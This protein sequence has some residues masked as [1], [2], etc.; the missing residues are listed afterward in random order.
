MKR[1]TCLVKVSDHLQHPQRSP[2]LSCQSL[3][4]SQTT[5]SQKEPIHFTSFRMC[6]IPSNASGSLR[7]ETSMPSCLLL[8]SHLKRC[9][10]FTSSRIPP[11]A[12]IFNDVT[13]ST[14][15]SNPLFPLHG[16]SAISPMHIYDFG[17]RQSQSCGCDSNGEVM[18]R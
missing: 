5:S 8:Y 10:A 4:A 2:T 17:S 1:Q 18:L 7:M 12:H 6:Q 11:H 3:Q 16:C 14:L 13:I 15:Q 9:Y